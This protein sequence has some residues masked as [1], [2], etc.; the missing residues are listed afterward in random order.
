MMT[1]IRVVQYLN[2]FFGQIGAE[3]SASVGYT[4]KT[5]PVGPGLALQQALGSDYEVVATIICGDDYMAVDSD[6]KALEEGLPLVKQFS[7]ELLFAGPAFAAGRYTIACGALCKAVNM[8][9]GIPCISGMHSDAPGVDIYRKYAYI[10]KTA[11][12]SRQMGQVIKEMAALGKELMRKDVTSDLYTLEYI[13]DPQEFNYFPM[14]RLRNQFTD[15][16]I[17]QRSVEKLIQKLK[18]KPFE[19]EVAPEQFEEF[20]A[21]KPIKDIKTARIAFVTDGGLVPK[22]NPDKMRTRSNLVWAPYDL[23]DAFE[24]GDYEVVH[25]GYFNDYVLEDPNRLIPYEAMKKLVSEGQ[26]GSM[27]NTYYS[28][29]ACTTVSKRGAEVGTE[30]AEMMLKQGNIDAVILTS[31]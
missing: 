10:I 26:V 30:M 19:T 8:N 2:Q 29:P 13:P 6:K 7:P 18:G 12:Q 9:L 5:G 14:D 3:K 11:N 31:T 17:A 4:V 15:K 22:G 25:A 16:T 23:K 27:D 21:P 24:N 1:K 28:M 20:P